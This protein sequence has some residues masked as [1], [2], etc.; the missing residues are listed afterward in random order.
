MHVHFRQ[1][2]PV[3]VLSLGAAGM[4]LPAADTAVVA[5][6]QT[7]LEV[8]NTRE[9]V[10]G[11]W[12]FVVSAQNLYGARRE[13]VARLVLLEQVVQ[14]GKGH[15]FETVAEC[16]LRFSMPALDESKR[17]IFCK[18]AH[19]SR[20]RVDLHSVLDENGR[21]VFETKREEKTPGPSASTTALA[22]GSD[23]VRFAGMEARAT[24]TKRRL[25]GM[26]QFQVTLKNSADAERSV[27]V[28]IHLFV[29]SPSPASGTPQKV[30]ECSVLRAVRARA[31]EETIV[32]CQVGDYTSWKTEIVS[33]TGPDGKAAP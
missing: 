13:I 2:G 11:Y 17:V 1:L 22:E 4:P 3:L 25:A 5:A 7:K 28:R 24:D 21:V 33:V 20:F 16:P 14:E 30:A 8:G 9:K 29:P 32:L 26:A 31:S 6:P 15:S 10:G 23:P 18:A 12:K 19:F 27:L